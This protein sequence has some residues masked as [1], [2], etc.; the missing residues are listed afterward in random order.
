MPDLCHLPTCARPAPTAVICEQH[1]WELDRAL[2]AVPGLLLELDTTLARQTKLGPAAEKVT[3]RGETAVAF[4]VRAGEAQAWLR[5][6]L[7]AWARPLGAPGSRYAT[8]AAAHLVAVLPGLRAYEQLGDL[9]GQVLEAVAQA[10]SA[11]DTPAWRSIVPVGT[12]PDC[13]GLVRAFIPAD[14]RPARIGCDGPA[15]HSWGPPEW[16]RVAG[17]IRARMSA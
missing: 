11:I 3:G 4:G 15:R 5:E 7:V 10:R 1:W 2:R 17:R 12:C 13:A 9:A 8:T 6:V 16:P 14:D